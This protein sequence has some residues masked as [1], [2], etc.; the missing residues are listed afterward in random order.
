MPKTNDKNPNRII[1][2]ATLAACA[3]QF[4]PAQLS[5]DNCA[6]LFFINPARHPLRLDSPK[7][8]KTQVK[9][10]EYYI[11][12][13][14][15]PIAVS[16]EIYAVYHA[17]AEHERYLERKDRTNGL[18]PEMPSDEQ[19]HSGRITSPVEQQVFQQWQT[20]Q[21]YAAIAQLSES[22]QW[23][24]GELYFAG[25]TQAQ[26]SRE[27]GVSQPAIYYQARR[28]LKKLRGIFRE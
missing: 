6:F 12:V 28:V 20:E 7:A 16:R 21:L 13:N 23:L 15:Q 18:L 5:T 26:L 10:K 14:G 19:I 8:I 4:A 22:E 1:P 3:S 27:M 25:K 17:M 24:V 9:V 11:Y 2:C